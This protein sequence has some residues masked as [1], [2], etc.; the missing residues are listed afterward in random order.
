MRIRIYDSLNLS[1]G[2]ADEQASIIGGPV[3]ALATILPGAY[4]IR[5]TRGNLGDYTSP[6]PYNLTISLDTSDIAE[7]NNTFQQAY[8]VSYCD[9]L[10]GK[11]RPANDLDYF[12]FIATGPSATVYVTDVPQALTIRLRAY[13]NGQNQVGSTVVGNTGQ[14][15]SITFPTTAG[16]LFYVR[17]GD[18]YT[19]TSDTSAYSFVVTDGGPCATGIASSPVNDSFAHIYPNP[20]D[21]SVFIRLSGRDRNAHIIV[22]DCMGRQVYDAYTDNNIHNLEMQGRPGIFFAHIIINDRVQVEKIVI[23][24]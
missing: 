22:Y 1:S 23:K 7:V 3:E 10:H 6:N 12:S 20:S 11:I 21:G 8:H 19:T 4:Y 2:I 13:D 18:Q 24:E 16:D 15:V 5:V 17:V 14:P 9:T